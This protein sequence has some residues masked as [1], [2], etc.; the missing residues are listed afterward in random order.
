MPRAQN[1][2]LEAVLFHVQS[3]RLQLPALLLPARQRS[4]CPRLWQLTPTSPA[5]TTPR[6][7]RH[8]QPGTLCL[9]FW[10]LFLV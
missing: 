1:A 10:K 3:L 2:G 4:D 8:L 6:T 9:E 7:C 5:A